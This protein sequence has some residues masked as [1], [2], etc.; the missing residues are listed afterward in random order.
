MA[1]GNL[2]A[3]AGQMVVAFTST[4]IGLATGTVAYVVATVRLAWVNEAV[5]EQRYLAEKISAELTHA[6]IEKAE[7]RSWAHKS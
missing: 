5:R 4:I 1:G 2:E 7:D 3:M 6:A